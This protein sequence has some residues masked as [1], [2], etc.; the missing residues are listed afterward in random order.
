MLKN[1]LLLS[2]YVLKVIANLFLIMK[3][4]QIKITNGNT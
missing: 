3:E 1:N 4:L 2:N